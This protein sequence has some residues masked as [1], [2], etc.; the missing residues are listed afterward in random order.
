MGQ[1]S[2]EDMDTGVCWKSQSNSRLWSNPYDGWSVGAGHESGRRWS[3]EGRQQ[4]GP[5]G[6]EDQEKE[7][8]LYP[9]ANGD[10][11]K[12]FLFSFLF[13]Y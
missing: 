11:L 8:R 7:F 10:S 3:R 12:A 4:L 1:H 13:F 5:E 6:L 9:Q 2:T